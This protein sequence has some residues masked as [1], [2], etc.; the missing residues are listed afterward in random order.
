M[1]LAAY[2]PV[3]LQSTRLPRK[4]LLKIGD[5]TMIEHV[6]FNT[7]KAKII[8]HIF[9]ATCDIEIFNLMKS[10]GADVIMTSNRHERAT[11]RIFEAYL[12]TNNKIKKKIKKIVMVQG[13]DP[14]L[15][16]KMIEQVVKFN[17]KKYQV[18]NI[19]NNLNPKDAEDP[20]RVKVVVNNNFEAIYFSRQP[21]PFKKNKN[22]KKYLKQGNI[23]CFTP[24]ILKKYC[25][26]PQ[27]NLEIVESVDMNRYIE[28]NFRIKM[29]LS[30]YDTINVD[31]KNDLK[32]VRAELR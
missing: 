24:E 17:S 6:Y 25:S 13:D 7:L 18:T 3:R 5:K 12:K 8:N 4:A 26:I 9:I 2:I 19:C 29:V 1:T 22:K 15:N 11:D 27:S 30:K 14:M 28:N 31:T 16:P 23:F 10:V 21:I 20:N 32:K